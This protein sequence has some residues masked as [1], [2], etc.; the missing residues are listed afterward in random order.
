MQEIPFG[1]LKY[2]KLRGRTG[3][4]SLRWVGRGSDQIL[5]PGRRDCVM[6]HSGSS[7]CSYL[8][9]LT[10]CL[11]PWSTSCHGHAVGCCH[12]QLIP[13]CQSCCHDELGV[14]A[15]SWLLPG[16]FAVVG[17]RSSAPLQAESSETGNRDTGTATV[18]NGIAT[19]PEAAGPSH[20]G[21]A[22]SGPPLR[23]QAS[24]CGR[25]PLKLDVCFTFVMRRPFICGE[26]RRLSLPV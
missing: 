3:L 10:P 26:T 13:G 4:S 5:D 11:L 22:C 7:N 15:V 21:H 18:L 9:G 6:L 17:R 1:R 16:Q 25:A 2:W 20:D 8:R 14:A 12:G 23:R 19:G 24:T